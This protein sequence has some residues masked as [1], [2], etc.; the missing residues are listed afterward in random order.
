MH[1]SARKGY[2]TPRAITVVGTQDI[3]GNNFVSHSGHP[4]EHFGTSLDELWGGGV[5]WGPR[6]LGDYIA[7]ETKTRA[8]S[9]G[10]YC[11]WHKSH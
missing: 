1:F 7:Y 11:D 5:Q 3:P 4:K 9:H 6:Y 2:R 8:G 10:V